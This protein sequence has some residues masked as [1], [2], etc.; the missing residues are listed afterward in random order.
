MPTGRDI[1]SA[2]LTEIG[3][4]RAG[5]TATADQAVQGLQRLD[6]WIDSLRLERFSMK[7]RLRTV[8]A[9]T[10]NLAT[11]VVGAG[12]QFN[13]LHP[14]FIEN[15]SVILDN[16]AATLV[17]REIEVLTDD[18]WAR[19]TQKSLTGQPEAVYFDRTYSDGLGIIHVWPVPSAATY[20]IVIYTPQARTVFSDLNTDYQI[21][22]GYEELF[23]MNLAV[24][25]APSYGVRLDPDGIVF[26]SATQARERVGLTNLQVPDLRPSSDIAALFNGGG[27]GGY[28]IMSNR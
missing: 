9:M 21:P 28:D 13:I 16:T 6:R 14:A 22:P 8:R 11:Y 26:T 2:A 19:I 27:R 17:E 3:I 7:S 10:A 1:V 23:V 5:S 25:L 15:A 20:S 24:L 12:G 18:R 4:L